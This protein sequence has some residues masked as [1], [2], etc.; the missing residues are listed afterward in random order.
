M[1]E[2]RR[3]K[4]F[5]DASLIPV[6]QALLAR[7]GKLDGLEA[8]AAKAGDQVCVEVARFMASEFRALAEELRLH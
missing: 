2:Y 8:A 3:P 4:K 1:S 5:L 7:A 6:E